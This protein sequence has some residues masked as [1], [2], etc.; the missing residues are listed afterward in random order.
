MCERGLTVPI[1][2]WAR[3]VV[4]AAWIVFL[5][6]SCGGSRHLS[7]A[8]T[9]P[10]AHPSQIDPHRAPAETPQL[11][12][13]VDVAL[14]VI[15]ATVT[16]PSGWV[17]TSL[18]KND[19]E[20]KENGQKQQ[21]AFF[22]RESELPLRIALLVDSSLSTARDLKFESEAATRFFQSVLRPQDAGAIFDFSYDVDQLT[23]YTSNITALSR[24]VK[25]IIP[26]TSTSLFDAV[27]LA[28]N[29]LKSHTQKEVM[30]IVSD[31]A[32]TTSHMKFQ[33][34]LKAAH[35]AQCIIYS[36]VIV[37]IKNDA[38]RATGGE[39]ALITLSQETGGK[40]FF[41]NTIGELDSIYSKISDELRT[42]YTIGYYSTVQSPSNEFRQISLAPINPRLQVR[43]RRGYFPTAK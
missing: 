28:A 24:A 21:I 18:T 12:L 31:G 29:T 3:R 19:F 42:Q 30:V 10:P 34:A 20:L 35:E 33:D 27:Y 23:G 37:P 14:T 16:N 26:G 39:H 40:A 11:R 2:S 1:S 36:V 17:N 32:D 13:K 7:F 4:L 22:S 25:G 8:Q 15:Y 6:Q 41:P 38:G 43:T 5:V 9:N